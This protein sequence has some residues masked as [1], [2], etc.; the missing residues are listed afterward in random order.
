MTSSV[1]NG[2]GVWDGVALGVGVV[3]FVAVGFAVI[4]G[5]ELGSRVLVGEGVLAGKTVAAIAGR[6]VGIGVFDPLS[7]ACSSDSAASFIDVQADSRRQIRTRTEAFRSSNIFT[8][9]S[10]KPAFSKSP[11]PIDH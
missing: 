11:T 5:V 9:T 1:G 10:W 7:V 8:L 2:V 6:I 4:V 3:V